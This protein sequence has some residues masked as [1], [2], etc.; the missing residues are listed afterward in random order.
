[1]STGAKVGIVVGIALA[2][3]ITGFIIY[4]KMHKKA[5]A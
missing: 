2:L 5:A 4:K 3:G 1:M